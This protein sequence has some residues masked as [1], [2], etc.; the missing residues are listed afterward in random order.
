MRRTLAILLFVG[1]GLTTLV[2][3]GSPVSAQ[4]GA[5]RSAVAAACS[6]RDSVSLDSGVSTAYA[7]LWHCGS[8]YEVYGNVC[9]TADDDRTAYLDLRKDNEGGNPSQRVQASGRGV[10]H[11]SWFDF[12]LDLSQVWT[13]TRACAVRCSSQDV[14]YLFP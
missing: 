3:G 8:H 9:D 13:R 11:Q 7:E 6:F 4:E 1:A 2:A 10:C 5:D 14:D 12:P